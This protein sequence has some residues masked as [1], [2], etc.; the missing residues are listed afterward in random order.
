MLYILILNESSRQLLVSHDSAM[1]TVVVMYVYFC[2][3][4]YAF[5]V[6]ALKLNYNNT[7]NIIKLYRYPNST[8]GSR[9]VWD[10]ASGVA[11]T[12]YAG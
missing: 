6:C 4:A 12:I 2:Y 8:C 5:I 10:I 9:C 11:Y 1:E 3:V 7:V